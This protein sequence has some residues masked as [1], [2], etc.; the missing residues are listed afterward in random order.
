MASSPVG[1]LQ[2]LIDFKLAISETDLMPAAVKPGEFVSLRSSLFNFFSFASA[3][4]PA[5]ETFVPR[6]FNVVNSGSSAS[7]CSAPSPTAV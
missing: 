5:S 4:A 6:M 1:V 2:R 7:V 3:A